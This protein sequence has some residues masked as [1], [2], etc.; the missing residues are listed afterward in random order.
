MPK[1][2]K[3]SNYIE[4]GQKSY[5]KDL[6]EAGDTRSVALKDQEKKIDQIFEPEQQDEN[7]KTPALQDQ[8][9]FWNSLTD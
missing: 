9:D 5:I 1:Q 7:D 4:P 2:K 8:E 3:A 6:E